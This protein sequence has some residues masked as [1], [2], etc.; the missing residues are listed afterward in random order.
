VPGGFAE[1]APAIAG[2]LAIQRC[3]APSGRDFV[4]EIVTV[5]RVK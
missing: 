2:A 1:V 4:S 3:L 5:H